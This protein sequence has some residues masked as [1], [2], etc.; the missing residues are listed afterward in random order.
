MHYYNISYSDVMTRIPY[1]ILLMLAASTPK[2]KSKK[3]EE[4]KPHLFDLL[5]NQM[6]TK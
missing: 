1:Q 5:A 2:F 3:K 6:G 4:K